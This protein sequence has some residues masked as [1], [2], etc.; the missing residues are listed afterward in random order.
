MIKMSINMILK[1]KDKEV[2]PIKIFIKKAGGITKVSEKTGLSHATVSNLT[3]G[4]SNPSHKVTY[5]I[6]KAY[7]ALNY[8]WWYFGEKPI[9]NDTPNDIDLDIASNEDFLKS[10]NQLQDETQAYTPHLSISKSGEQDIINN[11]KAMILLLEQQLKTLKII[12]Q[13]TD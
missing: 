1:E 7:P 10:P 9:W 6:F 11:Q 12:A 3:R 5:A 8:K 2:N 13:Q 4:K